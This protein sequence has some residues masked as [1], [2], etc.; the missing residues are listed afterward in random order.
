[1]YSAAV[2]TRGR[3]RESNRHTAGD[4]GIGAMKIEERD[5]GLAVV[6]APVGRL[7]AAGAP[8]LDASIAAA[9]KT[10]PERLVLDCRELAYISS[11]GMRSLLLGARAC[12]QAGCAFAVAGLRPECR[13]I[14]DTTGLLMVLDC[15][16][17]VEDALIAPVAGDPP[18]P[19]PEEGEGIA[20]EERRA[21][22]AIVLSL[23]GRL[24]RRSA[25]DLTKQLIAIVESGNT[26][27]V[28]DCRRMG[29]VDSSGLR[30]LLLCARTC[31]ERGGRLVVAALL[32]ECLSIIDMGGFTSIIEY[33]ETP[34]AALAA[35]A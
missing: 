35:L 2:W 25:P 10:A 27:I 29:Y 16:E 6:L 21:G 17:T 31:Q 18:E 1:M 32:P 14:L 20:I 3:S 4:G 8:V 28:L 24:D 12:L 13:S 22:R 33:R 19:E 34:E 23:D 30:A 26:R 15:P 9:A 11:A 5:A 7:D